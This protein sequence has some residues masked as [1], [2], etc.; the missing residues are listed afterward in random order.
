MPKDKSLARGRVTFTVLPV[1]CLLFVHSFATIVPAQEAQAP[2]PTPAEPIFDAIDASQA[3]H[4]GNQLLTSGDAAA[5]LQVYGRAK[6]LRPD[7][8]EVAFVQ[9]LA[10]Y[11][12]GEF[13]KAREAFLQAASTANDELADD[14]RYGLATCDHAEALQSKDDPQKSISQLEDAMR[15]YQNVLANRPDHKLARESNFKAASTWRQIKQMMQ[16]QQ[17]QQQQQEGDKNK[18]DQ[19]NKDQQQEN[20]QKSED[21]QQEQQDQQQQSEE[22]QNQDQQQQQQSEQDQSEPQQQE[23]K[24]Q[25]EQSA[26]QKQEQVSREQ[27]ERKLREMMQEL[28][29]RQ[30][31]RRQPV[32]RF[33]V[34]PVEKDW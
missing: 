14:A 13:D 3:V 22:Q 5:A 17:Q 32:Q 25:Q 6:E 9:G 24:D 1:L 30:K 15:Q 18:E 11:D 7:A 33:P 20:Q 21:Q 26:T 34:R 28:R 23:Q 29:D 10:H 8:R 31:R 12:L 27:A 16:Q 2:V 19:E 4:R